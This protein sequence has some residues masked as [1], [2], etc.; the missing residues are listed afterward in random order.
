VVLENP[1]I[2]TSFFN[3]RALCLWDSAFL[4]LSWRRHFYDCRRN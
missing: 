1:S 3:L 2:L 4:F